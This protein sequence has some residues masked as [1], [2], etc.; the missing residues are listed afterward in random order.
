M[1]EKKYTFKG[2]KPGEEVVLLLRRHWITQIKPLGFSL[3]VFLVP[4]VM[5]LWV[6]LQLDFL[7][8]PGQYVWG[9]ALVWAAFG[10]FFVVYNYLDWYLDI[11]LVTNL[12][13]VDV[14][15]DGLFHRTVGESPLDHVQDVIY[16]IKGIMPTMFNY[17]NVI[18]HTSGPS[19]DIVF[20]EVYKP[21]EVQRLLFDQA[22]HYKD[23]NTE[24]P[25]TAEDLLQLMLDHERQNLASGAKPGEKPGELPLPIPQKTTTSV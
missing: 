11:Y 6:S 24:A 25:A 13:I 19:G 3:V 8:I 22:D 7:S 12:R 23:I 16:E 10:I 15:Q 20:E 18:I 4:I 14:T 21:Q 9:A 2:Q 5:W 1:A 17:G